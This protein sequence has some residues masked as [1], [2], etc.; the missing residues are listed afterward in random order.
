[1]S[2]FRQGIR[3]R[4]GIFKD[5]WSWLSHFAGFVAAIVGLVLLLVFCEPGAARVTS[6]SI[7]GG[8]LVALFAASAAYHFFDFGE[9]GNRLL[10]RI[11]HMTIYL[12][13]AGTYVPGLV[14][15]LD[16]AW[17]VVM[18]CIVGAFVVA[19]VLLK[20]VWLDAPHWLST[21]LYLAFGW[22][23]LF[24]VLLFFPQLTGIEIFWLLSGGLAY[25]IGALI[26]WREWPDP[27]P[28]R[29]GHHEV[30]HLF[31]LAGATLHFFYVANLVSTPIA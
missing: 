17:R 18:L 6:A 8:T 30:W 24:P 11:D 10:R 28:E 3:V 21:G 25:T 16:G 9:R 4:F 19:G 1:M 2:F 12:L 26:F 23:S 15:L 22:F 14:I 13:I 27:W 29:F 5:F 31:V 20:V 7:Y